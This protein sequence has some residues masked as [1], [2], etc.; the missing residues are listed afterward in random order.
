MVPSDVIN[1][2]KAKEVYEL[3]RRRGVISKMDLKEMSGLTVSTLTRLLDDLTEHQLIIEVGL[4]E[5]TG[6]RRPILYRTN[7][8]FAYVF[9]LEISRTNSK[10]VLCDLHLNKMDTAV[11]KMDDTMTPTRLIQEMVIAVKHMLHK[12]NISETSVLGM[13]I[14][15]VGPLDRMTGTILNPQHFSS[16]GWEN[17][18]ICRIAEER[19]GFSVMLNNGANAAVLGE[20]WSDTEGRVEH[21]LYLHVGVGIRSAMISGGELV[22]GA[23]DREGAV[24]QMVI[25]ADGPSPRNTSGNY[26][27]WESFVSTYALE[28]LVKSQLK[29]GRSSRVLQYIDRIEEDIKYPLIER[30]LNE[31]DALVR[32]LTLQSACYFGIGISNLLNILHPEKVIL[33]GPLIFGNDLFY[34]EAIRVALSKTYHAPIYQVEFEKS[35]LGD[36]AVAIGAAANMVKQLTE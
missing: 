9:G 11:W 26:G 31:G 19:L 28:E 34:K 14:G 5:S 35:R 36:D 25:Q 17:V 21:L 8:Q 30:A 32:D 18:E 15:A 16:P 23:V 3:I 1:G 7:P 27:S 29:I 10:L 4:G 20:Y 12:H 6:G 33:G 2:K 13:G 24:G 22:Y